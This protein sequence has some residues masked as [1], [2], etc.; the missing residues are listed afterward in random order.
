MIF[1]TYPLFA[2]RKFKLTLINRGSRCE[3]TNRVTDTTGSVRYRARSC[4]WLCVIL[5]ILVTR[6]KNRGHSCALQSLVSSL[7]H[8]SLFARCPSQP[9]QDVLI[10]PAPT[11]DRMHQNLASSRETPPVTS[12][13]LGYL[14]FRARHDGSD[15]P[16]RCSLDHL[17]IRCRTYPWSRLEMINT[18]NSQHHSH[19]WISGLVRY[20]KQ[21]RQCE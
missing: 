19:L 9:S 8:T 10:M 15:D 6:H 2:E 14:L 17:R 11:P 5:L 3:P 16:P 1:C 4:K 21:A 12:S 18:R 20:A 7:L 13:H